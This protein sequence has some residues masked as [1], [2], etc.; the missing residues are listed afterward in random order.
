MYIDI[1]IMKMD[2][3]VVDLVVLKNNLPEGYSVGFNV[4]NLVGGAA[5]ARE[6]TKN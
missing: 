1:C 4:G 6:T 5:K 3:A 2:G